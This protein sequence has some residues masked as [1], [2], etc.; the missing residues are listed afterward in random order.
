MKVNILK[1]KK[2]WIDDCD[3]KYNVNVSLE[4]FDFGIKVNSPA[5]KDLDMR[6]GPILVGIGA[7]CRC[8]WGCDAPA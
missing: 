1:R 7:N 5:G 4:R 6:S 2:S 8:R 3:K